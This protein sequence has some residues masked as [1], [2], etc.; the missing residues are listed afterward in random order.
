MSRGVKAYLSRVTELVAFTESF[1]ARQGTALKNM[2]SP[3]RKAAAKG[4]CKTNNQKKESIMKLHTSTA[5]ETNSG[6]TG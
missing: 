1:H 5:A 4:D 2:Q 6:Q 3:L